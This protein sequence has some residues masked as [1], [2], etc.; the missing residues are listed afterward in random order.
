[1]R[2]LL[3][4]VL[5]V[6][7][8]AITG[9]KKNESSPTDSGGT[10]NIPQVSFTGPN[11]NDPKAATAKS[12][13]TSM[14]GIMSASSVFANM[15][16]QQNGNTSTWTYGGG[17]MSYTFTGVKQGDGSYTWSYTFTG[18]EGGVSYVNF[19][20]WQGTTSADGKSGSWTF[21]EPGHTG[22]TDEYVYSTDANGVLTGTWYIYL[23]NGSLGGKYVTVNNPDG[24]GSIDI[25]G[26]GTIKSYRAVW[27]ADQSGEEWYYNSDGVTVSI[28]NTWVKN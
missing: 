10:A 8:A 4:I 24:S 9:C 15:P 28:H 16:A 2:K 13:A 1:M 14:N 3:S 17:G 21:F 27:K 5:I 20:M 7:L 25:Y 26:N 23:T 18:T 6:L 11:T 12:Y 22:K 19:T